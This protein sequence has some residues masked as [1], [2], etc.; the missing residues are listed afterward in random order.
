MGA[1]GWE[2]NIIRHWLLIII[3]LDKFREDL[4]P[5]LPTW[6]GK[7]FLEPFRKQKDLSWD[8]SKILNSI[9]IVWKVEIVVKYLYDKYQH[10]QVNQWKSYDWSLCAGHKRLV[11]TKCL[12]SDGLNTTLISRTKEVKFM[13]WTGSICLA[14]SHHCWLR[15]CWQYLKK[16]TCADFVH[17]S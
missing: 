12:S 15:Q 8:I 1:R 14:S 6:H 7:T 5:K 2:Y 17:T 4:S 9:V 10:I 3:Y 13:K 11:A 16:G